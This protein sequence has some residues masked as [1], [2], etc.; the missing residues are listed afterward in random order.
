MGR[1]L[2]IILLGLSLVLCGLSI[3]MIIR[4]R[5]ATDYVTWANAGGRFFSIELRS[6]SVIICAVQVDTGRQLA[7]ERLP[8]G[9]LHFAYPRAILYGGPPYRNF[10]LYAANLQRT[11]DAAVFWAWGERSTLGPGWQLVSDWRMLLMLA[12]VVPLL[13]A[14]AWALQAFRRRDRRRKGQ[15][16]SCGYDLRASK[17]RC[18]ECGAPIAA[19]AGSMPRLP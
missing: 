5:W 10:Q 15:C 18:P 8:P 2:A 4:S 1:R 12:M 13:W 6:G 7:W 9:D 19:E 11:H 17:E 14:Y 16:T 3:A